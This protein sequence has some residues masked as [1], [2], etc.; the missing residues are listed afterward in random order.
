MIQFFLLQINQDFRDEFD[1][2]LWVSNFQDVVQ[3]QVG[4]VLSEPLLP[5]R[6]HLGYYLLQLFRVEP[7][8]RQIRRL[9]CVLSLKL[10]RWNADHLHGRC[11][12]LR[13]LHDHRQLLAVLGGLALDC[14][15]SLTHGRF[16][17]VT[18]D[19]HLLVIELLGLQ[20]SVDCWSHWRH[21]HCCRLRLL[22]RLHLQ[23][24]QV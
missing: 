20:L 16:V 9:R 6:V 4:L 23:F 14:H 17:F 7:W 1:H 22:L 12:D 11:L 19:V 21:L 13:L 3:I 24:L 18:L 5:P 2:R 8:L 10:L 15:G